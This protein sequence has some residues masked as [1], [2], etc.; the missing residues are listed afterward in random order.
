[1][2]TEAKFL[3]TVINS[4]IRKT[5]KEELGHVRKHLTL[6]SHVIDNDLESCIHDPLTNANY[7]ETFNKEFLEI[8]PNIEKIV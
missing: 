5:S 4:D 1:M 3:R 8:H 2:I 7:K 6:Q